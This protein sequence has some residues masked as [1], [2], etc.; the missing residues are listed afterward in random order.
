MRRSALTS[1]TGTLLGRLGLAL[2]GTMGQAPHAAAQ[3]AISSSAQV[4]VPD[5][6]TRRHGSD[7]PDFLG[8]ERNGHSRETGLDLDWT[9]AGPTLLWHVPAGLGFSSPAV[10]DDRAYFFD[11][12]DDEAR[13]RAL[14]ARSMYREYPSNRNSLPSWA[15]T[16]AAVASRRATARAATFSADFI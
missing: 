8:P 13:L 16:V 5:L 7:W 4:Q 9:E 1:L 14:D 3:R 2:P 15:G 6:A 12:V 11:R 10:A